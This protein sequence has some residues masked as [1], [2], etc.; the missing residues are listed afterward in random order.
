[1]SGGCATVGEPVA[2]DV[3]DAGSIAS[4]CVACSSPGLSAVAEGKC[5]A[6]GPGAASLGAADPSTCL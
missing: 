3:A 5:G 6:A 4:L 1:M 2:S